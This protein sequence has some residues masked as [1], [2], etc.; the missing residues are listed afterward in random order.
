[1]T[2]RLALIVLYAILGIVVAGYTLASGWAT[3]P[4]WLLWSMFIASGNLIYTNVT[5]RRETESISLVMAFILIAI[6]VLGWPEIAAATI[7]GVGFGELFLTRRRW[8]KKLYNTISIAIAGVFTEIVFTYSDIGLFKT[9]I[10]TAIVFD[11]V[12]YILLV[13]IWLRVAKQTPAEIADSYLNTLYVIP[14][15]ALIAWVMV[16]AVD[17]FG[18]A[19]ILMLAITTIMVIKPHYTIPNWALR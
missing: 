10:G 13:P 3:V 4:E 9:I 14:A 17:I 6:Q 15:S 7:L 1:M 16:T 12:L 11:I 18:M 8:Y 5:H 19:G 2:Q